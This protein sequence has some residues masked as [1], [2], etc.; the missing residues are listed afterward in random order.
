MY[1]TT[2]LPFFAEIWPKRITSRDGC[3]L[4]TFAHSPKLILCA[5]PLPTSQL[6]QRAPGL[7]I[8][9]WLKPPLVGRFSGVSK[10]MV[11]QTYVGTAT[12]Q[13]RSEVWWWN[14]RW[15]FGGR[16]F[17]RFSP[18]KEARKSPS[19]LRRK[20]ATNFAENFANFTLEIAGAY[21]WF[22]CGWQRVAFHENDGKHEN[23][24]NDEGDSDSY[25]QG[26]ECWVRGNHENHENDENHGNPGCKPR[27]PQTTGLEI[28][29][30][31]FQNHKICP[32]L[33]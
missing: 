14:L 2:V 32:V 8:I 28:P 7:Q 3:V 12:T 16:C 13:P 1:R 24:E 6:L 18:A 27:L 30:V 31:W 29:E 25:K 15:S 23:D 33:M 17:W 10:P 11:C 26:V 22:G 5:H 21:L 20:F 9:W 19:K 4:L